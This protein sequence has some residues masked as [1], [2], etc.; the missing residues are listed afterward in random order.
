MPFNTTPARSRNMRAIRANSNA[1][2]ELRLRAYLVKNRI[3]GWKLHPK[4]VPG[5]PD[6]FFSEERLA[7]FVDGCFW[8]GCPKCGHI[9]KSN[10]PYWRE[11]LQ[12]NK[13]RDARVRRILRSERISLVRL[14]ECDLRDSPGSCL[15]KLLIALGRAEKINKTRTASKS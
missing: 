4:K 12:R 5:C 11:K 13:R 2:T 10:R 14:W 7:V 8:H 1:T 6:F 15:K 9:P 3:A